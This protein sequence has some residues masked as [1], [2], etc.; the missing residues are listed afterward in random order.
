MKKQIITAAVLSA[1][2]ALTGCGTDTGS[3]PAA[4][5]VAETTTAAAETTSAEAET[6]EAANT[7]ADSEAEQTTASAADTSAENTAS[8]ADTDITPLVG[9]WYHQEQNPQNGAV[10]DDTGVVTVAADCTYTYQPKDGSALKKGTI[11]VDYDQY[12]DSDKVPFWAFYDN[13][14]SFFIGIYCTQDTLNTYYIGNGGAERLDRKFDSENPFEEYVGTWQCDRCS[15]KISK[16]TGGNGAGFDVEIHWADSASEDNIW[17]YSCVCSDDGTFMECNEG[18]TLT[19][20]V[21]AEDGSEE[22][23][24]VYN[25]GT[26]QFN[27]KGGTLFWQDGKE[28]KGAQM[29]FRKNG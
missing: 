29:G 4:P 24:V 9:E 12:P 13:D 20:I 21:T 18:G 14:G 2:L 15:I 28:D 27:I 11:K 22:R 19:H 23:T 6:T 5:S 8:S 17:T 26:V 16:Q 7:A 3:T 10:Y 1:L 25:D